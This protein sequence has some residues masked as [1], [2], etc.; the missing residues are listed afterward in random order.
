MC[1][2]LRRPSSMPSM[3]GSHWSNGRMGGW[4]LLGKLLT[5]LPLTPSEAPTWP[6]V[7]QVHC[8]APCQNTTTCAIAPNLYALWQPRGGKEPYGATVGI[9]W[10]CMHMLT[11]TPGVWLGCT[12]QGSL[13]RLLH[14][15]L[16]VCKRRLQHVHLHRL[17]MTLL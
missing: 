14:V 6:S 1:R 16:K 4:C 12:D 8:P 13:T 15:F 2:R 17:D 3:I 5:Q 11:S 10:H 9:W 7:M